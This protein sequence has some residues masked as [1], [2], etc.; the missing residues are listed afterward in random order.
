MKCKDFYDQLSHILL[1]NPNLCEQELE[2]K[3]NGNTFGPAPAVVCNGI[4]PGFDWDQGRLLLLAEEP[5]MKMKD[6]DVIGKLKEKKAY[7]VASCKNHEG[8]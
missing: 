8:K 5:I 4:Y 3:V 2:I 7:R 6:A 1:T